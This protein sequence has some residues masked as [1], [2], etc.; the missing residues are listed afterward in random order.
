MDMKSAGKDIGA[1]AA[2]GLVSVPD[3]LAAGLLAGVSPVTGLYAY[4]VGTVAGAAATSSVFMTVQAT[5]AMA[6]LIADVPQT[7]GE[8]GPAALLML[9]LL[10][11]AIL[12]TI[13]LLRLGSLVRFVPNAVLIGFVNAVA[14][15]IVLGQ[16][17]TF[18]G[19]AS[20]AGH[21]MLRALDTV[22]HIGSFDWP[23]LIIGVATIV[24]I[25]ALERTPLGPLGLF[26]AVVVTS[27]AVALFSLDSVA[28]LRDIADVP[29][30]LPMPALPALTLAPALLLPAVSLAFVALIQG[31][32]ISKSVPN[33]DGNYPDVSGDIRGQGVANIAV[34]VLQGM[35]VGGSMSGTALVTEAGARS[36]LANFVA[37]AVMALVILLLGDEAGYI[38]MPA[39]AGLLILVGF[40]TFK[41]E[42]LVLL[43]HTGL[44]Q[45]T[46]VVSTFVLTLLIPL[47]YAVLVG[48]AISVILH[49]TRQSNKVKVTRWVFGPDSQLP[50]ECDPPAVLEGHDVVVLN[51]YGSLFFASAPVFEAQLPQLGEES[52]GSVV[53]LR[54]RGKEDLGSTF[55]QVTT[56]YA[57]KLNAAGSHFMLAGVGDRVLRQLSQ[58]GAIDTI[59]EENVFP[60]DPTVGA[61]VADAMQRAQM[62]VAGGDDDGGQEQ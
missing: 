44:T 15:N 18:T 50:Q 3:G 4:L 62:L 1:G 39:L 57:E 20:E 8:D 16:F 40:R 46:V 2:L 14:V 55:I 19:Y 30:S 32:A 36:R 7:K 13:G 60:V 61:S 11:G 43:W 45:I 35:P 41:W 25:L 49:V 59:G 37:G 26:A 38:A 12:L 56:R 21:R 48:V 52:V 28:L 23:T 42:S 24:L 53:I 9:A 47:Q 10:T 29:S 5:G 6:V 33:P 34:G 54:L 58:T 22:L 31:A 51:V 27:G 17:A